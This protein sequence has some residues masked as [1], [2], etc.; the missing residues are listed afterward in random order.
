MPTISSLLQKP[1]S[2]AWIPSISCSEW[3]WVQDS[4]ALSFWWQFPL[5]NYSI[6]L[7][8]LEAQI[9][10]IETPSPTLPC[11]LCDGSFSQ[12]AQS[13]ILEASTCLRPPTRYVIDFHRSLYLCHDKWK[14]A[15]IFKAFGTSH[16]WDGGRGDIDLCPSL[17]VPNQ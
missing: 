10:L 6:W 13:R 5:Q 17:K 14:T 3:A 7:G 12:H 4:R 11:F 16:V 1:I 2:L 15:L 8:G 9:L